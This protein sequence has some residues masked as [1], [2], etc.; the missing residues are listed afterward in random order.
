MSI[1]ILAYYYNIGLKINRFRWQSTQCIQTIN[2]I[3][4]DNNIIH[5]TIKYYIDIFYKVNIWCLTR[6]WQLLVCA[7]QCACIE[8]LLLLHIVIYASQLYPK[9]LLYVLHQALKLFFVCN[10]LEA[11]ASQIRI[12]ETENWYYFGL[13]I[14][15]VHGQVHTGGPTFVE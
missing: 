12:I 7:I 6:Y 13:K 8:Q 2:S 9:I 3:K 4:F 10:F 15:H 14:R 1:F 5:F 11:F